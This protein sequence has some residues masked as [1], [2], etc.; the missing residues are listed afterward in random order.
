MFLI[1]M[2][3]VGGTASAQTAG[4]KSA[5][6]PGGSS[7]SYSPSRGTLSVSD[8]TPAPG[9]KET[10]FGC[11]YKPGSKVDVD[12]FS[13]PVRVASVVAGADG[14]FTATFN[15]PAGTTPGSHT[16]ESSGVNS[17]GQPLLLSASITV[18]G[19]AGAGGSDLP[20]TGA[21]STKPLTA[22][23][24]G[25]VLIGAVAVVTARRRRTRPAD[26]D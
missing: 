8:T 21:S 23:G 22:A 2:L 19:P 15:I 3:A 5:R 12:L 14:G 7:T 13:A 26:I 1:A 25:L 10:A 6:C 24:A 16:V 17:A 20:R 11:G 9:D 4:N 18:A